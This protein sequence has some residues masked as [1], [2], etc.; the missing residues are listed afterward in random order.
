MRRILTLIL[1]SWSMAGHANPLALPDMIPHTPLV[2]T[3]QDD[4]AFGYL[5]GF[6]QRKVGTFDGARANG[7]PVNS[8]YARQALQKHELP[9]SIW[10][11]VDR[12]LR[13]WREAAL[14]KATVISEGRVRYVDP[15]HRND[16]WLR[17]E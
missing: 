11:V 13:D 16:W 12:L 6:F 4:H 2:H 8:L 17:H 10:L 3:A 7:Y 5:L 15:L 9:V 14:P 1:L